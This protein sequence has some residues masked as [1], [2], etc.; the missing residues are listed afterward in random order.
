[1]SSH[2]YVNCISTFFT[3]SCH[4]TPKREKL[5]PK[6]TPQATSFRHDFY[7]WWMCAVIQRSAIQSVGS[8][9]F[10]NIYLLFD[11]LISV[12]PQLYVFFL[13]EDALSTMVYSCWNHS[14]KWI[15]LPF[16]WPCTKHWVLH[17]ELSMKFSGVGLTSDITAVL[18]WSTPWN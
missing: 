16:H 3:K 10:K 11:S 9:I 8:V 13:D 6:L 1:M 17:Y 18:T 14:Y 2:I 15:Y 5:P 4:K 12:V 7:M